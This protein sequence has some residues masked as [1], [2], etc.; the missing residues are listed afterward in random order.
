M[1]AQ[2]DGTL[3]NSEDE[4]KGWTCEMAISWADIARGTLVRSEVP[5]PGDRWRIGLYR[6]N[7]KEHGDE[8]FAEYGAWSPTGTWYHNP[9]LFGHVIFV[10]PLKEKKP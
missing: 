8:K 2:V 6:I 7:V 4:D 5:V 9:K 10:D 3:N 1:A